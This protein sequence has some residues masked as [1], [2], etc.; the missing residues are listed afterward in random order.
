MESCLL[1]EISILSKKIIFSQKLA[2]YAYQLNNSVTI[3][4]KQSL[5]L[6]FTMSGYSLFMYKYEG[7]YKEGLNSIAK[8]T[9]GYYNICATLV[10][11]VRL[12]KDSLI[13]MVINCL[14]K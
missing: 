6:T 3:R 12:E 1:V 4:K 7:K 13:K 5:S 9:E 10:R 11:A 8:V 2:S 14:F